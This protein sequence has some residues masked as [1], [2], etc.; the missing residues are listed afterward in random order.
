[1]IPF[2]SGRML[3]GTGKITGPIPNTQFKRI[4]D[5]LIIHL[6]KFA[7]SISKADI[8]NENGLN[9]KL[10]RFITNAAKQEEEDFF[11]NREI[12]EDEKCG[13]SP[14]VDIGIYLYVADVY[15]Q[16]S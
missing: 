14:A 10:S 5:F 12:M 4:I 16:P 11:A 7:E 1:M 9:S 13:N 2:P 15:F 3:S 8:E 6:P